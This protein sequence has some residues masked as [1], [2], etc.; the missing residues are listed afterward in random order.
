ML[1]RMIDRNINCPLTSGA[2]RL[3]DAVS[4]LLGL[5]RVASYQAEGPMKLESLI[6]PGCSERYAFMIDTAIRFD[7]MAR[8][9]VDDLARGVDKRIIATMFH[10]T[11]IAAIFET[12]NEISRKEKIGKVVLSGG[13]FQ[14]RY[15]LEGTISVLEDHGFEVFS[16]AAVPPNDGGIALGQLAVASKRRE[17]KCV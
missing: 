17:L 11:I 3:F 5:C 15:L 13:V 12:V 14:N 6:L 1:A 10:N 8:L 16:H 4:A 2:G 7:E 9:I